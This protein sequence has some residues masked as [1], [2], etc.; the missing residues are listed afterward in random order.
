MIRQPIAAF[1]MRA[2]ASIV[3]IGLVLGTSPVSVSAADRDQKPPTAPVLSVSD[4][5]STYVSL[6]WTASTDDQP[7]I[8]YQVF[9]NGIPSVFAGSNRSATVTGLT[10]GTTYVFTIKARDNGIN[11]SPPSNAVTLTTDA[12]DPNDTTPPT[13]PANLND[14]DGGCGETWLSWTQSTDNVDPQLA[15]RYE[16]YVNGVFRPESTVFGRGSTVAFAVVEGANTFQV[17]AIDGAGNA[18]TPASVTLN[19]TGLCQ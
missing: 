13:T 18:S 10:P 2:A 8:F 14:V 16:I 1:A 3:M 6:S 12:V 5:G 4:A 19:I 7:Y 17:F 15:I 9:V 11:W